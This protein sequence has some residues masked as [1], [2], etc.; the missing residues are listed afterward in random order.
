MTAYS[1][2]NLIIEGGLSQPRLF[3][4]NFIDRL[5]ITIVVILEFEEVTIL[6]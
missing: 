1:E 2:I 5:L 3:G 4:R 6:F